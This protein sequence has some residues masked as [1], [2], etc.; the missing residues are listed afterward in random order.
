MTEVEDTE[1]Q[2]DSTPGRAHRK[3][4]LALI[5]VA[6]LLTFLAIFAVWANR[7]LL[8]TDNWTDTSTELLENDAIRTQIGAFLV[9][10]LYANVDV[11]GELEQVFEQVLQPAG[12]STL[13]GPA[14][15][16]LRSLADQRVEVLL[17]RPRVQQLWEAANRRAHLRL[18]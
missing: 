5:V 7:Q 2:A 14:A 13:A 1:P 11:K 17:Q 6:S 15:S 8:N 4:G 9:E 12:A 16:G 3:L 18:L 10:S